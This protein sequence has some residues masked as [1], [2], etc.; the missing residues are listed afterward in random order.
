MFDLDDRR[1]QPPAIQPIRIEILP[2]IGQ[3]ALRSLI[4]AT[5]DLRPRIVMLDA[6]QIF[7]RFPD[8]AMRA[9]P[10]VLLR[11]NQPRNRDK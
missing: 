3:I 11:E 4:M 8:H 2:H 6:M 9:V 5:I 10:I 1:F 7:L